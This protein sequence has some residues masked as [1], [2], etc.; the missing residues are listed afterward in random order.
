MDDQDYGKQAAVKKRAF[1]VLGMHRSGTSSVA[2]V[3]TLLGAAPPRTLMAAAADNP[4]GFFESRLVGE[5]NDRILQA[6]GSSWD[7]WRHFDPD[8]LSADAAQAF[9]EEI[10][11][12]LKQEFADDAVIVLKDPRLC[13]LYPIWEGVLEEEGYQAEF[14]LPI[15]SPLEVA[16]SLN[17]RNGMPIAAGL[18]LWL[19]HVLEAEKLTRDRP[20]RILPW[21]VF[22]KDWRSE[23]AL[24]RHTLNWDVEITETRAD[25]IDAFLSVDL[26]HEVVPDRSLGSDPEAHSWAQDAYEAL[27]DLAATSDDVSDPLN[28]LDR[29]ETAFEVACQLYG[30]VY[31]SLVQRI[32][33]LEAERAASE[34]CIPEELHEYLTEKDQALARQGRIDRARALVADLAT[35]T[36][37]ARDVQDAFELALERSEAYA[38]RIRTVRKRH[39]V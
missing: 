21:R 25:D 23:M 22:M 20:R 34:L 14:V 12:T 27:L 38:Q 33:Q 19:R 39:A 3:L 5:L 2:G 4:K 16:R 7:D 30:R 29:V 17:R 10:R 26:Q 32:G 6:G 13:R 9:R 11:A 15:R 8:V 1:I 31:Q 24:I 36:A 18:L 28:R 37:T 35:V